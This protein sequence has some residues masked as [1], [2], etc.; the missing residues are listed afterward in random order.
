LQ[1]GFV[2]GK[3]WIATPVFHE[4]A[5]GAFMKNR[6]AMTVFR[7]AGAYVTGCQLALA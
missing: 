6:L 1:G 7:R 3:D 5:K 4:G 2:G